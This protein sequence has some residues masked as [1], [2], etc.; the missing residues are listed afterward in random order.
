MCFDKSFIK[1]KSIL[2]CGFVGGIPIHFLCKESAMAN[3]AE[4]FP[5]NNSQLFIEIN[6]SVILLQ[7]I[8]GISKLVF[9]LNKIYSFI[10]KHIKH[11]FF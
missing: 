10:S 2:C 6:N 5:I 1:I 7:K 4:K 3:G 9:D 11:N 8:T